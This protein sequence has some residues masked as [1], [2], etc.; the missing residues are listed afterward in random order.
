MRILFVWDGKSIA[1]GLIT[2]KKNRNLVAIRKYMNLH[3]SH[4]EKR[5]PI[6]VSFN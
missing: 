6:P 1:T 2:N 3:Q 5:D 4:S